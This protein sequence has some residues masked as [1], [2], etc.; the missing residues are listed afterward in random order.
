[1]H[2]SCSIVRCVYNHIDIQSK[3]LSKLA[4]VLVHCFWTNGSWIHSQMQHLDKYIFTFL[5]LSLLLLLLLLLLLSLLLFVNVFWVRCFCSCLCNLLY[6]QGFFTQQSLMVVQFRC[7][8]CNRAVAKNQSSA[9]WF[10]WFLG[11][12]SLQQS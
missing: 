5:F 12:Y 1:M 7:L 2:T 9:V 4:A 11:T 3:T 10:V 8:V 6:F